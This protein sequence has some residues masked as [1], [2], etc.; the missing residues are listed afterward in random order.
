MR[1]HKVLTP[2]LCIIKMTDI[3][4]YTSEVSAHSLTGE[5]FLAS[6]Q[7]WITCCGV[8]AAVMGLYQMLTMSL[9]KPAPL[10]SLAHMSLQH[11]HCSVSSQ[12][13]GTVSLTAGPSF[14]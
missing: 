7:C 13:C 8:Q 4:A 12:P 14:T 2:I 6:K 1:C 10:I 9:G 3:S 11:T 5:A